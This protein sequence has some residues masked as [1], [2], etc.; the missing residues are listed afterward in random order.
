MAI[1]P[2]PTPEILWRRPPALAIAV[3]PGVALR[4]LGEPAMA[5]SAAW[6]ATGAAVRTL[7][8]APLLPWPGR[9]VDDLASRLA[10]ECE[11]LIVNHASP[12]R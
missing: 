6:A 9:S 2:L 3:L 8:D 5:S 12:P 1:A 4:H 11:W 10:D 7:H